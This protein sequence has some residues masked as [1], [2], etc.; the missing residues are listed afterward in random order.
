MLASNAAVILLW[1]VV[2]EAHAAREAQ[3]RLAVSE[4]RLRFSRDM[5]D[6]LGHSL[7]ALAVK[8]ELAAR[9]AAK[10]PEGAARE[11]SAVQHLARDALREVRAAV[12]GYRDVDL[13]AETAGVQAVLTA[14]GVRCTVSG[15]DVDVPA[16][17]RAI[18]SWVVREGT[19]NVLRHSSARRCSVALRRDGATLVTEVFND[20]AQRSG[21]A[22]ASFGNGL[23][24]LSERVA[25]AGGALTAG[26]TAGQDGFLLRAV[27]PLPEGPVR[28]G[29]HEPAGLPGREDVT[30]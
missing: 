27:L 15:A 22:A 2:T 12:T 6:L 4:E 13:A 21:E 11:M 24:G 3:A 14:A 29:E 20:G 25:A 18:A 26:P 23:S 7:S 28:E 5:H 19:T 8:S 16:E 1:D 30:A 9:L 10:D 17:Q